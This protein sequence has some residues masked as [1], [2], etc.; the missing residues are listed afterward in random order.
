MT[1]LRFLC[2]NFNDVIQEAQDGVYSIY[3]VI[4]LRHDVVFDVDV[5]VLWL[6]PGHHAQVFLHQLLLFLDNQ[7]QILLEGLD[8]PLSR[9]DLTRGVRGG[10]LLL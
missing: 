3:L 9:D 10:E 7:Q 1:Q 2:W 8:S 6:Q 5:D 4:L